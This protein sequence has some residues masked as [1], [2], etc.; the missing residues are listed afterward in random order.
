MNPSPR[1]VYIIDDEPSV[2]TALRWLFESVHLPVTHY[3]SA[4]LFLEHY[5]PSMQGCI[6]LD[7]R[8]QGMSGLELLEHLHLHKNK[9]PVIMITGYGDISMAVRAMKLGAC[10]FVVKPMNDQYLLDLVQK[11]MNNTWVDVRHIE[12]IHERI[13]SLTER[14]R[15]IIDLILSGKLT[16]EIAYE[17]SISIST[18]EAHRAN[19][20]R[21]MQAKNLAQLIKFY[22]Q[23]QFD[24]A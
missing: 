20:M 6:L 14:E 5:R 17:L 13:R 1:T 10:D 23:S 16:K 21:K 19:I 9:I 7:V 4:A 8:M 2:G 12:S 15:Q 22:L 24:V 3:S 11:Q 18:V